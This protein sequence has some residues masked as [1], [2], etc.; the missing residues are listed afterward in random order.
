MLARAYYGDAAARDPVGVPELWVLPD[1]LD[2][3]TNALQTAG[4][5]VQPGN[6]SHRVGLRLRTHV[7]SQT[8]VELD[9]PT[10]ERSRP[11]APATRVLDRADML[12]M[13]A[14]SLAARP[15]DRAQRLADFVAVLQGATAP[16]LEAARRRACAAHLDTPMS[17][18]LALVAGLTGGPSAPPPAID[19]ALLEVSCRL[20]RGRARMTATDL[21]DHRRLV[22]PARSTPTVVAAGPTDDLGEF[23]PNDLS[24]VDAMLDFAGAGSSDV[25][26]DLGCGDG[27]VLIRAAQRHG[28]KAIGVDWNSDRVE[29]AR[30][31]VREAGV[32]ALVDIRRGDVHAVDVSEATVVYTYL[33]GAQTTLLP[34]LQR[35]LRPGARL[36]SRDFDYGA[37]PPERT[38]VLPLAL[39]VSPVW[40]FR[41]SIESQRS[42]TSLPSSEAPGAAHSSSGAD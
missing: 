30:A 15:W 29:Q 35:E 31:H 1:D 13:L 33:R 41:W 6:G 11:V 26:Y 3:A 12:V 24:I 17:V 36:V 9:R 18:A 38:E 40:L 10:L 7:S 20:L 19:R 25:L 14:A 27:R 4:L 16:E 2:R 39:Q 8:G 42:A 34:R 28:L 23:I 32:S 21:E 5:D 22:C 37:W